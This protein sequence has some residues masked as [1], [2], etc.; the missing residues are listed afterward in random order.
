MITDRKIFFQEEENHLS[1]AI[2]ALRTNIYFETGEDN[3]VLI[4][5][6]SI[7]KEGK[8]TISSNFAISVAMSGKKVLLVDCDLRRPRVHTGFGIEVKY[9]FG[10][11]LV[12]RKELEDVIL[13]NVGNNLDLLPSNYI[14]SN[15]TE[16]FLTNKVKSAIEKF[17]NEYDLVILD[18]PPLMVATDAAILSEYADGVVYVI[19]YGMVSK[20][21]LITC[22]KI[23]DRTKTKIIGGVVNKIDKSGFSYGSYGYYNSSHEYYTDYL[24][25]A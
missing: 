23:L 13:R 25:K 7:P 21:E 11:F 3:N 9:G 20:K 8:S 17:R 5:T 6:S 14:T 24:K 12:G 19:G 16:L 22:K 18:T 2:R 4:F 10:D 1:E 15:V